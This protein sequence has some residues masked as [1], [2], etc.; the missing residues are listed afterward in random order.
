MAVGKLRD[1]VSLD[2]DEDMPLPGFE[3]PRKAAGVQLSGDE[4]IEADHDSIPATTRTQ[5]AY[6]AA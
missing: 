4:R 1:D 5:S 2:A 6:A 3:A